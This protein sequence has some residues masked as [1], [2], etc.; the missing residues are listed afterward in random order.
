LSSHTDTGHPLLAELVEQH[1][2]EERIDFALQLI[3]GH[4]VDDVADLLR[5]HW[6]RRIGKQEIPPRDNLDYLLAACGLLEIFCHLDGGSEAI[7]RKIA[8]RL[9]PI[10]HDRHVRR[11]YRQTY[12]IV[13]PQLLY[14]RL[15][16]A[17]PEVYLSAPTPVTA[18]TES[19]FSSVYALDRRR[20]D[21][22]D[23]TLFLAL[24]DDYCLDDGT[25]MENVLDALRNPGFMAD[26]AVRDSEIAPGDERASLAYALDGFDAFLQYAS[27][28][29]RLLERYEGSVFAS[30]V[31]LYHSYFYA[32]TGARVTV[33]LETLRSIVADWATVN[34]GG[35]A[36]LQAHKI[37]CLLE[38]LA[39]KS[40]WIGYIRSLQLDQSLATLDAIRD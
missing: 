25:R 26:M 20:I 14:D 7:P 16:G 29:L 5:P 15:I 11:Y 38:G 24:V 10:L 40:R 8:L 22:E 35:E 2:L 19:L 9:L 27:D 13:L 34:D 31:W 37:G 18:S 23:L 39:D 6:K 36:A 28:L 12:P 30:L 17:L 21:D 3:H 1:Q 32:G 4:V 33:V